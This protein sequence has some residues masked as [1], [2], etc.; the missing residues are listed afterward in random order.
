MNYLVDILVIILVN[1][2]L[3]NFSMCYPLRIHVE[4][5]PLHP[6]EFSRA[7]PAFGAAV[8]GFGE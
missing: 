4:K 6:S 8:G 2:A 3:V 1:L 5:I 7:V